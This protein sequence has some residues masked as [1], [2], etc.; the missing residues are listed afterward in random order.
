MKLHNPHDKFFKETFGNTEIAKD[1]LNNYLP[2]NIINII[3]IDTLQ[4]QKDS[5]INKELKECFTD[6]LF[7]VNINESEGNIYFLF[8]HKS[9]VSDD[10]PLQLLKYMLEIWDSKTKKQKTMKLPIII[11]LVIYQGKDNWDIKTSLGE[12]ITN[13][14]SLPQDIRQ[15]VPNFKYLIY[16]ISP[17]YF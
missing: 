12:I 16:D 3:D 6:L 1:F 10:I 13:Y 7:K 4:P 2:Q 8:E 17:Y 15:Y 5:F 11:P 9:Y 14:E